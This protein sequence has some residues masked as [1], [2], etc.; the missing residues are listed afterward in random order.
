ME[1]LITVDKKKFQLRSLARLWR[2][3]NHALQQGNVH[4]EMALANAAK[5]KL[6][7]ILMT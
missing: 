3:F 4:P 6:L 1:K 7:L 2:G 5:V